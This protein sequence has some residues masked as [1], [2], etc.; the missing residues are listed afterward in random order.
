MHWGWVPLPPQME[1]SVSLN[2]QSKIVVVFTLVDKPGINIWLWHQRKCG[3][4]RNGVNLGFMLN[5]PRSIN[6]KTSGK[7]PFCILF[8]IWW[9][10]QDRVISHPTDKLEA[11]THIQ[12][13]AGDDNT[14]RPKLA[15][16]KIW[17]SWLLP[18][19]YTNKLQ[20]NTLAN[21]NWLG[22]L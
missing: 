6:P 12:T 3:Q 17:K 16:S 20:W 7:L 4:A 15:S 1:V 22:Y 14:R 8:P 11:D 9:F 18:R 19:L 13:K 5:W 21:V 10:Q 2:C